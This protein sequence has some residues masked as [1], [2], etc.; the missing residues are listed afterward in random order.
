MFLLLCLL[1]LF[2]VLFTVKQQFSNTTGDLP[3]GWIA[4]SSRECGIVWGQVPRTVGTS[5]S[6]GTSLPSN[7]GI[8]ENYSK[9][10]GKVC[11]CPDNP[12]ETNHCN[13]LGTGPCLLSPVKHYSAPWRE[14]SLWI[15]WTMQQP[16]SC[17]N[18][19]NRPCSSENQ[20][21]PISVAL[22]CK[23]K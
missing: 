14:S 9:I 6:F 10:F 23:T 16:C 2:Q 19:C 15:W 18:P 8:L 7:C 3:W 11:C 4:V 20:P 21:V 1:N 13:L 5:Q 17:S 12:R 22:I